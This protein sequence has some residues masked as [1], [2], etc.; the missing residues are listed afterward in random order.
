[1]QGRPRTSA[2]EQPPGVQEVTGKAEILRKIAL[3]HGLDGF[4]DRLRLELLDLLEKHELNIGLIGE[5]SSGKTSLL[6]LLLN[7]SISPTGIQPTTSAIVEFR[8]GPDG[9][10]V[11]S[12][13]ETRELTPDQFVTL[14][15]TSRPSRESGRFEVRRDHVLLEQLCLIDTPGIEAFDGL[16]E[17]LL[18]YLPTIHVPLIVLDA[19]RGVSRSLVDFLRDVLL[20]L[21]YAKFAVALNKMDLIPLAEQPAVIRQVTQ[22]F[23]DM[24]GHDPLII[25]CSADP[26]SPDVSALRAMIADELLPRHW[27]IVRQQAETRLSRMKAQ[28]VEMLEIRRQALALSDEQRQQAEH[29][30]ARQVSAAGRQL[31]WLS[32]YLQQRMATLRYSVP[33]AVRQIIE[34]AIQYWQAQSSQNHRTE[35]LLGRL[36]RDLNRLMSRLQA[37]TDEIAGLLQAEIETLQPLS[38]GF[39]AT[40]ASP[41]PPHVAHDP[42]VLL[43]ESLGDVLQLKRLFDQRTTKVWLSWT[44]AV[45]IK[46]LDLFRQLYDELS[47]SQKSPVLE[48]LKEAETDLVD[49]IYTQIDSA[50]DRYIQAINRQYEERVAELQAIFQEQ[51][52]D[53]DQE[54]EDI[55]ADIQQLQG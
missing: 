13:T 31:A 21:D 43:S 45:V 37:Q 34:S 18:V 38:F 5:F 54:R 52:G 47:L 33:D 53:R 6:N 29:E 3:R 49:Q 12:G 42:M 22:V 17:L 48:L 10:M 51:V 44:G 55:E 36:G 41:T 40:E 19:T 23:R 35:L 7:E 27:E 25:P 9:Y 26:D 20:P 24:Q 4:T 46:S 32:E 2:E 11:H 14:M 28:L 16:L 8:H 30:L 50:K 15:T 1:M 39:T